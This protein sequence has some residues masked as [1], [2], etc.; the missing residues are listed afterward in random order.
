METFGGDW[1]TY[2]V[3]E[4][5]GPLAGFA[6]DVIY[7]AD[8]LLG[9][10]EYQRAFET[11]APRSISNISKANRYATEGVMTLGGDEVLSVDE[12]STS[13]IVKRAFGVQ[14]TKIGLK[15][16]RNAAIKYQQAMRGAREQDLRD[17]VFTALS[18]DDDDRAEEI[19]EEIRE[20]KIAQ[21]STSLTPGSAKR[22]WQSRKRAGKH[23]IDG[24]RM[25]P[26]ERKEWEN[27]FRYP[28]DD[29]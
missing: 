21:P 23:Y 3:G 26:R 17:K 29:E 15:W 16:Q 18:R 7:A 11:V 28:G 8:T 4:A 24:V 27:K 9:R 22:S 13:D 25:T 14:P 1:W 10:E 2:Y 20:F 12:L 5:F 19:Y 6:E